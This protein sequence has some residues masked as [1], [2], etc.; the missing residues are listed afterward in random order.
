MLLKMKT[1]I[2]TTSVKLIR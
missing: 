2:S 1:F